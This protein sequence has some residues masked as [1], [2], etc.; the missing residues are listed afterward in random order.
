M[1]TPCRI[2]LVVLRIDVDIAGGFIS[3]KSIASV[4]STPA[5]AGAL[6]DWFNQDILPRI[7]PNAT[8]DWLSMFEDGTIHPDITFS[9]NDSKDQGRES[10]KVCFC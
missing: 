9:L 2:T 5:G 6:Q 3:A 8:S 4:P 10:F 7:F 1:L